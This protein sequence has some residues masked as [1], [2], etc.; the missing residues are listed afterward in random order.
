MLHPRQT[1]L[2]GEGIV[3]SVV[4][5]ALMNLLTVLCL[6]ALLTHDFLGSGETFLHRIV[7]AYAFTVRE[8]I[9]GGRGLWEMWQ[10]HGKS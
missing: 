1:D 10:A 9:L 7:S 8:M 6:L 2:T 3:F 4:V 5:I